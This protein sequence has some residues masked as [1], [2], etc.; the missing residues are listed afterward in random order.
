[1]SHSFFTKVYENPVIAAVNNLDNLDLAIS[2]PCKIIFLLKGS[3]FNIKQIVDRAKSANKCILL[4]IDLMEGLSKDK[5]SLKYIH[6]EVKPDGI[7]TTKNNLIKIAKDNNIFIIQ[8]FFMLDSLSVTSSINSIQ[9]TKPDAIELL[10]GI[11]PKIIERVHNETR[12][13]II[14][15]GLIDEKEDVIQSLN[16]GATGISTSNKDVW[17]M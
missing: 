8:R 14:A 2:S 12:V 9:S 11:I 17:F 3:I 16:A 4:H 15:G 10:P 5:V 1:M 7:I 13:P 6:D